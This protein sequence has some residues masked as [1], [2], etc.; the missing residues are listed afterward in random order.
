MKTAGL[1]I[2]FDLSPI[3]IYDLILHLKTFIMPG[4]LVELSRTA[5]E[6]DSNIIFEDYTHHPHICRYGLWIGL[7]VSFI[8]TL[9]LSYDH[10]EEPLYVGWSVNGTTIVNPGYSAS[11]PPWGS[12][13][14]GFPSVTYKCPVD[15]FFHRIS[16]IS[17]A[18]DPVECFTVQ[19]LYRGP[20]D[21]FSPPHH[22]PSMY[23]CLSGSAI[24]W[25][26]DKLKAEREC[27]AA[28]WEKIRHYVQVAHVNPGDPV[29][30]LS[31]FR[32]E[33]VIQ[34]K[35][36][37]EVLERLNEKTQPMLAAAI[38]NNLTGMLRSRMSFETRR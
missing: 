23:V 19:V 28:F 25:P 14:P 13:V 24:E 31:R 38:R 32:G 21:Q 1:F 36:Q 30:W 16:F 5:V 17:T 15:G 10:T 22:G 18:G 3:L 29:E 6:T 12:P 2:T 20:N 4:Q 35:A 33:E 7:Q 27:L 34:L 37:V 26:E 11:T 9:T 8:E